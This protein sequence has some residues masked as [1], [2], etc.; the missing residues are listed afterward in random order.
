[1]EPKWPFVKGRGLRKLKTCVYIL[2][3]VNL[4]KIAAIIYGS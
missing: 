1:M 3:L 4:M 2:T